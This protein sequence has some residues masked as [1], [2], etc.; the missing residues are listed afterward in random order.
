MRK[1][2]VLLGFIIV[3]IF[4]LFI[5]FRNNNKVNDV[6]VDF[7][8]LKDFKDRVI[9]IEEKVI[10]LTNPNELLRV[11]EF[12]ELVKNV[13]TSYDI[14]YLFICD[15]NNSEVQKFIAIYALRELD[16][17]QYSD[18]FEKCLKLYENN[19]L[20]EEIIFTILSPGLNWNCTIVKNYEDKKVKRLLN[21]NYKGMSEDMKEIFRNV[22]LGY[23]WADIEDNRKWSQIE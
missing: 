1:I 15:T 21:R 9:L 22:L 2:F 10:D 19:Q 23:I 16:F 20:S 3:I 11:N 6:E 17:E 18:F 13:S 4:L 12:N 7:Q 14:V 8:L 5:F